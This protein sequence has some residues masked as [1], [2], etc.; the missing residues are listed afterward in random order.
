MSP[1]S[2]RV[3]LHASLVDDVSP[4]LVAAALSVTAEPLE[5]EVISAHLDD[6]RSLGLVGTSDE[7]STT[8]RIHPLLRRFLEHQLTSSSPAGMIQDMHRAIA[9]AAESSEWLAAAKHYA[10]GGQ[11][12]DGMR[13]L[14][15]AA[16][17]ALGTGA[18]GAAVAVVALMPE[19]TPP[20][21]VEVIK[22][23]ALTSG[24]HPDEALE[25]LDSIE[26]SSLDSDD[27]TLVALARAAALQRAGRSANYAQVVQGLGALSHSDAIVDRLRK[28]WALA[29]AACEGGSISEARRSLDRLGAEAGRAGLSHFAGIA[30]HNAATAALAQADYQDA[31][32]LALRAQTALAKSKVD[33]DVRPSAM[34]VQAVATAEQGQ[35]AEA[36]ALVEEAMAAPVVHPDVLADAAYLTCIAGDVHRARTLED[37]LRRAIASGQAQVGATYLAGVVRFMRLVVNGDY[38]DALVVADGLRY[39]ARDELDGT[40]RTLYLV[41]LA[42]LLAARES[43]LDDARAALAATDA[44]QAWRW[45]FRARILEAVARADGDDLARWI[46]DCAATSP[47]AILELAEVLGGALHLVHPLPQAGDSVCGSIPDAL[48]AG[49]PRSTC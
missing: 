45:E 17:E 21:A 27:T 12:D 20:P 38:A 13:V 42:S 31:V 41:A 46:S 4:A 3:L 10:L 30:L 9:R 5:P 32:Q 18:W 25:L 2:Q 8:S 35:L 14:G 28:T 22:A 34:A 33:E 23:R 11:P 19:T 24:G 29:G 7:G 49:T 6:A 15:M 37:G 44:Q 43:A 26:P 1:S 16:S 40:A 36:I 47:L 48:E 39:D